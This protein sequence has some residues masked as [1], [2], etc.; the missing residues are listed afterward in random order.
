MGD[1]HNVVVNEF[2]F[3]QL[4]GGEEVVVGEVHIILDDIGWLRMV[5]A[6]AE[7]IERRKLG[8]GPLEVS[9]D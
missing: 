2:G 9:D 6:I 8:M 7:A 5:V 4:V 3:R 1:E